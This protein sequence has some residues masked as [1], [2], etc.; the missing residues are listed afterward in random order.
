MGQSGG[1]CVDE[2]VAAGVS[3]SPT[4]LSSLSRLLLERFAD[5]SVTVSEMLRVLGGR[6]GEL[7]QALQEMVEQGLIQ[8]RGNWFQFPP[9]GQ[10]RLM[11]YDIQS[12]CS[13]RRRRRAHTAPTPD[14]AMRHRKRGWCSLAREDLLLVRQKSRNL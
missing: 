12:V 13:R 7:R 11:E 10:P 9:A 4:S 2:P 1:R 6:E 8:R 5:R 3:P 14:G